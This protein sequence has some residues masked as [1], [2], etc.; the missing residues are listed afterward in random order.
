MI[1]GHLLPSI[2]SLM[3]PPPQSHMHV[4]GMAAAVTIRKLLLDISKR[5]NQ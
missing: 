5:E 2:R 4:S 1:P 3:D